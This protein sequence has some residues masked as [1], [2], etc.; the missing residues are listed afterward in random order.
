MKFPVTLYFLLPLL[1][2]AASCGGAGATHL[3][4]EFTNPADP[5]ALQITPLDVPSDPFGSG[6][7]A[8]VQLTVTA[9]ADYPGGP[10]NFISYDD[11]SLLQGVIFHKTN[12][13]ATT[14]DTPYALSAGQSQTFYAIFDPNDCQSHPAATDI[15]ITVGPVGN[16]AVAFTDA[17]ITISLP[18][19][20]P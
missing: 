4:L 14:S 19:P 13:S 10:V 20:C 17:W 8:A 15:T 16:A 5:G 7:H 1:A 6:G 2:A 9:D 11:S 12:T 18:V 3:T